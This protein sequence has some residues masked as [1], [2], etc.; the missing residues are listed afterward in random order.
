LNSTDDAIVLKALMFL[1]SMRDGRPAQSIQV[2]S[3]SINITADS[4]QKA[5][6]IIAE[7]RGT[8]SLGGHVDSKQMANGDSSLMLS[9][10]EGAE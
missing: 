7:I 5:K 2:T 4:L 3:Q 9:G 8:P 6:D 1:V 10:V